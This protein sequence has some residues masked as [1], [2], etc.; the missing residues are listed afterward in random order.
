MGRTGERSSVR[1]ALFGRKSLVEQLITFA[2]NL[3]I[4]II[5]DQSTP[6]SRP[7][8]RRRALALQPPSSRDVLRTLAFSLVATSIGT[9]F[10]H[11]GFADS[12]IIS[13]YILTALLTAVTTTGRICTIVSSVLS[14]VLYNFCFVTPLFSLAS[15]DRSYLVTFGIMF[16]TAMA[17][18]S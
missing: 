12:S 16:A 13:L 7:K 17:P 2:P 3:D 10:R 4:Y 18:A 15:Y 11:L 8:G 14:V 6:P 5:P 9:A 1:Q